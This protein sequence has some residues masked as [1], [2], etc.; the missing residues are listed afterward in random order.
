MLCFKSMFFTGGLP[1]DYSPKTI[2]TFIYFQIHPLQEKEA[3]LV[4]SAARLFAD[5]CTLFRE[6][7]SWDDC[8][9][10]QND[11]A[12]IYDWIVHRPGNFI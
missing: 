1:K 3:S 5:D 2:I 8:I 6:I 11:L 9:Q 7:K 4:Y 10:L 12:M